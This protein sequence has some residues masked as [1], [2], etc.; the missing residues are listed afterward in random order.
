MRK[1]Q[2]RKSIRSLHALGLA[3]SDADVNASQRG[4]ETALVWAADYGTSAV[5]KAL[6]AR[7]AKVNARDKLGRTALH[8]A[9]WN[10]P[11]TSAH[12]RL[13][14]AAG[15]D[16]NAKDKQGWTPLM[17]AQGLSTI[18][19]LQKRGPK[20]SIREEIEIVLRPLL[21]ERLSDMWRAAGMQLFEIGVQRP[22]KNHKGQDITRADMRLHISCCWD[23]QGPEGK[24]VSSD[25]FGPDNTRRDE[26]AKPFYDMLGDP[27]LTINAIQ[28]DDRGGIT[29]RMS[30]SHTLCVRPD[31]ANDYS[32]WEQWRFLPKNKNMRHFVIKAGGIERY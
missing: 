25:D 24:I 21:G 28:A 10:G 17:V 4:G 31:W 20:M 7:G 15:A 13:L 12:V 32:D 30:G 5:V 6:L 11:V 2:Y 29:L 18:R 14:I 1:P 23:I 19:M 8:Y 27:V 16:I 3:D 22:C 26:A 9:A